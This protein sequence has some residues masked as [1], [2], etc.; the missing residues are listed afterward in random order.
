MKFYR[1]VKRSNRA[2]G[3][4]PPSINMSK[5]PH[6]FCDATVWNSFPAYLSNPAVGLDTFRPVGGF[7]T[8]NTLYK[9]TL[10]LPLTVF[11]HAHATT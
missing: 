10:T 8:P 4:G 11:V 1:T 2:R 5:T 7:T 9:F 6:S 3:E